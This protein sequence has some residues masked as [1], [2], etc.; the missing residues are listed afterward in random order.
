V[1]ITELQNETET[2]VKKKLLNKL[3]TSTSGQNSVLCAFTRVSANPA[4]H[5]T[6]E[7]NEAD[8]NAL[9]LLLVLGQ[10]S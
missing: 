8:E 10:S 7:S 4:H 9:P 3:Q 5:C 6:R 1:K 2:L